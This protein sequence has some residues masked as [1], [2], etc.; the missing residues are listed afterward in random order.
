[1]VVG[2]P[3]WYPQSTLSTC[4]DVSAQRR[5]KLYTFIGLEAEHVNMYAK[6]YRVMLSRDLE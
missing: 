6:N 1:M 5:S 3:P 4:L 2:L